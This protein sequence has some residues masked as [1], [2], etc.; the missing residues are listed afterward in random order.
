VVVAGDIEHSRQGRLQWH[1]G[2]EAG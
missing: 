1:D 2:V